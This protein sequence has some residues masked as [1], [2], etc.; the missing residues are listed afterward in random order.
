MS[1][2]HSDTYNQNQTPKAR[3]TGIFIPVEILEMD[4][5]SPTEWILLS[6]IDALH[7]KSHNGCFASNE[8][9]SKNLR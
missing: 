7:D 1:N 4:D 6:W 3:F 8:Y 2:S 5:L 9:L